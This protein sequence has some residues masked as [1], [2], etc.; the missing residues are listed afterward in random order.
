MPAKFCSKCGASLKE[1]AKFCSKCGSVVKVDT[2]EVAVEPVPQAQQIKYD[3][4]Q[5]AP[6]QMMNET[7]QLNKAKSMN[8]TGLRIALSIIC[9]ALIAVGVI[10]IPEKIRERT[11]SEKEDPLQSSSSTSDDSFGND[12]SS[13]A[14]VAV[15]P[16]ASENNDNGK[17]IDEYKRINE[18]YQSGDHSQSDEDKKIKEEAKRAHDY[19]NNWMYGSNAESEAGAG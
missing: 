2:T 1:N 15:L 3:Y 19:M 9:V 16:D 18:A 6:Q 17:Y 12:T 11:K 10:F 4:S 7:V 5:P 8:F 14:S 13:T